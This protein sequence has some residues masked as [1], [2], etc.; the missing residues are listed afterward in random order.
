[1]RPALLD[2]SQ[3]LVFARAHS[4]DLR[5]EWR[6]ANGYGASPHPRVSSPSRLHRARTRASHASIRIGRRLLPADAPV[7]RVVAAGRPDWGR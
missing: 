3:Q 4:E 5:E 2:P 6:L 7:G 1:M